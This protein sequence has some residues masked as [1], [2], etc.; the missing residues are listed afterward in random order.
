MEEGGGLFDTPEYYKAALEQEQQENASL[1]K[2]NHELETQL[3]ACNF[4]IGHLQDSNSNQINQIIEQ[5]KEIQDLKAEKCVLTDQKS[6]CDNA[7]AIAQ[8]DIQ[9]ETTSM[10][11]LKKCFANLPAQLGIGAFNSVSQLYAKNVNWIRIQAEVHEELIGRLFKMEQNAMC[12][13]PVHSHISNS[14]VTFDNAHFQGPMYEVKDN[15]NVRLGG[16]NDGEE[17]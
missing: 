15:N 7:L 11:S 13:K 14:N 1:R 12:E 2:L 9:D 6:Q 10:E 17:I 4:L 5:K 8:K 3:G 16:S